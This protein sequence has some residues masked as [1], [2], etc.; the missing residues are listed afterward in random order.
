VIL[1]PPRGELI[2]LSP[3]HLAKLNARLNEADRPVV[4]AFGGP[5]LQNTVGRMIGDDY[6][7]MGMPGG[8]DDVR[9]TIGGV[10]KLWSASR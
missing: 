1:A 10:I 8:F 7:L 2:T 6:R 9:D 3:Q 5:S 4:V